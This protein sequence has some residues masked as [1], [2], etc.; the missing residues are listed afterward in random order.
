M[1]L[2]KTR[3]RPALSSSAASSSSRGTALKNCVIKSTPMG[4]AT[5]GMMRAMWVL[6]SPQSAIMVC[7]G[8]NTA[9]SGTISPAR[10]RVKSA[11]RPGN[12]IRAKA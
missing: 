12:S 4:T 2:M 11:R 6:C 5:R 10:T 3:K 8:M 1:I 9:C 7:S